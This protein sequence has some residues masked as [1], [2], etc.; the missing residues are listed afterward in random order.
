MF[1]VVRQA[2]YSSSVARPRD[3]RD[4]GT[5]ETLG[6]PACEIAILWDSHHARPRDSQQYVISETA[7]SYRPDVSGRV[8]FRGGSTDARARN[9]DL[10]KL[11][12]IHC[13]GAVHV[14]PNVGELL[15]KGILGLR[16]AGASAENLIHGLP[17]DEFFGMPFEDLAKARCDALHQTE[18]QFWQDVVGLVQKANMLLGRLE[19]SGQPSLRRLRR[20]NWDSHTDLGTPAATGPQPRDSHPSRDHRLRDSHTRPQDSHLC[21]G[22]EMAVSHLPRCDLRQPQ[23]APILFGS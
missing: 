15:R 22:S 3:L 13:D 5:C 20:P 19:T 9:P 8:L 10:S 6:Q 4:L 14:A 21:A 23:A 1:S 17:L 12:E 2:S 16:P 11:R 18:M 7:V